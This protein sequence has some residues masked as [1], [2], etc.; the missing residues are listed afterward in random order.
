[1]AFLL[2][3]I[4]IFIVIAT[5]QFTEKPHL[6]VGGILLASLVNAWNFDI[7]IELGVSIF[8]HDIIFIPLFCCGI[9]RVF[10]K[11]QQ[12]SV[13]ILW[14]IYGL[15]LFY[16][17]F[18][19]IN[20]FGTSAAADFRSCFYYWT[21]TLYFMS[22]Q[23]TEAMIEKLI[24]CWIGVCCILL[25]L[26]Y[27]RFAADFANLPI[28]QTWRAADPTGVRFRVIW[29]APTYLLGVSV[30]ILFHKYLI[31][32]EKKPS[33]IIT[34]LFIIAVIV[35]QHRSVWMATFIAIISSLLIPSIKKGK[36]ISNLTII[37]AIGFILLIPLFYLGYADKFIAT[38]TQSAIRATSLTTDTFG[39]RVSGW[40]SILYYY[41]HQNFLHQLIGDPFGGSYGRSKT[42]PHNF[43]FQ[44]LLRVG[45][46]GVIVLF[47]TY[48]ST[49]IKLFSKL[50][51]KHDK[52]IYI[53]LYL[54][55]LI[56]QQTFYIPY[57]QQ[58]EHGIILGI[59]ISLAKR[60]YIASNTELEEINNQF[61]LKSPI[62][63]PYKSLNR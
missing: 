13:S 9:F 40:K 18:N 8:A 20:L 56:G 43:Y 15:L 46:F 11:G 24:K 4:I 12:Q 63:N 62:S 59:A 33:K 41:E 50:L 22:F 61:F 27:F 5:W 23:Y 38:I 29:A 37:S 44:A 60:K 48:T 35:L 14:I 58:A 53:S 30:V 32:N 16:Q 2:I 10:L 57:G 54:M 17:I 34:S 47:L 31:P 1:M 52:N 45:I 7:P 55:L 3:P 26:V 6:A 19:G 28:A 36:V 25:A 42:V 21:G 51:E 39:A 49:M